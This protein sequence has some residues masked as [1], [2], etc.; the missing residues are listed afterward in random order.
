MDATTHWSTRVWCEVPSEMCIHHKI[1][2][3]FHLYGMIKDALC[4]IRHTWKLSEGLAWGHS[5]SASHMW[6][7]RLSQ[8]AVT[9]GTS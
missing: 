5:T 7:A 6:A 4:L 1:V 9:V 8:A 2:H 3:T